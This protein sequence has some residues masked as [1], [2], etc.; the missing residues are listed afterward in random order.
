MAAAEPLFMKSLKWIIV[1]LLWIY[2]AARAYALAITHDEA[3]SFLLIKT[4]YIKAMAGTAN[5][6]WL[7]SLGMKFGSLL[8][9]NEPWQLRLFS[10][11]A[12]PVY[13]F[14]AINISEGLKHRIAG[15]LLFSLLVFNPYL[16]D[17]FS[18]AR[19]YGLSFAF[20]LLSISVVIRRIRNQE[21]ALQAWMPAFLC[22]AAAVFSNYTA[23]YF[24]LSLTAAYFLFVLVTERTGAAKL[25]RY[26][27]GWLLIAGTIAVAAGNLLFIK[28]YTGDLEYGGYHMVP[29]VFGSVAAGSLYHVQGNGLV[30]ITTYLMA[31]SSLLAIIAGI[32]AFARGKRTAFIFTAIVFAGMLLLNIVF[33]YILGTPYLATRTAAILYP[34]LA[35]V[36]MYGAARGKWF[37]SYPVAGLMIVAS[38]VMVFHFARSCNLDYCYEWKYTA[39]SKKS[40]DLLQQQGAKHVLL[41]QWYGGVWINYYSVV[42]KNEYRFQPA[43]YLTGDLTALRS[44]FCDSLKRYDHAVLMPPF[45]IKTMMEKN[46]T[47]FAPLHTFPVT[48][49][50]IMRIYQNQNP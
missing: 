40:F 21:W 48:R 26:P 20:V 16:V 2:I 25:V 6:H 5:N 39:D 44:G 47:P 50:T 17:F 38:G 14:A 15:L 29:S 9:G 42:K 32:F 37:A 36:V 45:E 7:N 11:L 46:C 41:W 18:L 12:W 43:F 49:A 30:A 3:Y 34:L 35:V 24:F 31:G 28:H 4:N 19:G 8:L 27:K 1:F 23:L 33:H 22:G 13:G 10:I